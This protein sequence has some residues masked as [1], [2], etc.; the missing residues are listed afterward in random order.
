MLAPKTIQTP[1]YDTERRIL[2]LSDV[3]GWEY[4]F[5]IVGFLSKHN[6]TLLLYQVHV[7]DDAFEFDPLPLIR[8]GGFM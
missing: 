3:L 2:D 5:F 4:V 7:E 6:H 1:P 8:L